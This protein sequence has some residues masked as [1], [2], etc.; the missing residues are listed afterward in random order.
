MKNGKGIRV[1]EKWPIQKYHG[2]L[3]GKLTKVKSQILPKN[4]RF[5]GWPE[6]F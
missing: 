4:L 3:N 2:K 6:L 5:C 1:N